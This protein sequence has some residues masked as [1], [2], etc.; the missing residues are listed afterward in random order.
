MD[1]F[2]T[3]TIFFSHLVEKV[4]EKPLSFFFNLGIHFEQEGEHKGNAI[5][6]NGAAKPLAA[7]SLMRSKSISNGL[8]AVQPDPVAADI[9]RKEPQ[10]E[11]FI[12]M[13]TTPEGMALL[14]H[15]SSQC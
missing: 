2:Y 4:A 3:N 14:I 6:E 10:Q 12:K 7:A 9:L 11:S 1:Q 15:N 8:H 13:L 5:V